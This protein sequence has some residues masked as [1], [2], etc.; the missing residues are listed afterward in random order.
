MEIYKGNFWKKL[1]TS[2]WD[3]DESILTCMA[4]GYFENHVLETWH[5]N[6]NTSNAT[7]HSNCSSLTNC[8][9]KNDGK[10]QLCKGTCSSRI[11]TC[12]NMFFFHNN[13][14]PLLLSTYCTTRSRR[15][16]S[17]DKVRVKFRF[18]TIMKVKLLFFYPGKVTEPT[19]RQT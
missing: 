3:K 19:K 6:S 18:T 2:A 12:I 7:V 15:P 16:N 13:V 5:S 17:C 10:P 8:V 9:N 11:V 14:L 1:C 4:V